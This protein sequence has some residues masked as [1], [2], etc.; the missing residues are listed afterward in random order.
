[1]VCSMVW[2]F[3]YGVPIYSI[4]DNRRTSISVKVTLDTIDIK[5]IN[6]LLCQISILLNYYHGHKKR[7]LEYYI[8][9]QNDLYY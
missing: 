2:F 9:L 3:D 6:I 1:M 5:I 4:F 7:R 8:L